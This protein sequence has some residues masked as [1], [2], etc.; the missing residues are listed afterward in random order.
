MLHLAVIIIIIASTAWIAAQSHSKLSS[1]HSHLTRLLQKRPA[2]PFRLLDLPLEIRNQIYTHH[3]SPP[4]TTFHQ[5]TSPTA[6]L[7]LNQQIRTEAS[8]TLS[9]LI[10]TLDIAGTA[11]VR[12]LVRPFPGL[13]CPLSLALAHKPIVRLRISMPWLVEGCQSYGSKQRRANLTSFTQNITS[14][15]GS[16]AKARALRRI[17]VRFDER[18]DSRFEASRQRMV[19]LLRPLTV[20][21]RANP[22][23]VV[24]MPGGCVVSSEELAEVQGGRVWFGGGWWGESRRLNGMC[25][26]ENFLRIL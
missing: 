17:E 7:T 22:K 18:T 4:S 23:V 19:H 14:V 1:L 8:Q 3:F 24:E 9:H 2:Q 15:C 13:P 21:R 11:D 20:V 25:V 5:K 6:I 10:F 16:L 26:R 12:G